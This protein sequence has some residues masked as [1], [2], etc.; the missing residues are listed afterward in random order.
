MRE[1]TFRPSFHFALHAGVGFVLCFLTACST[2]STTPNSLKESAEPQERILGESYDDVWRAVQLAMGNYP[3]KVNNQDAG[4]LETEVIR[5]DS[6]WVSPGQ[7]RPQTGGFRYR[8]I[9]RVIKGRT[10]RNMPA[11]QVTI[12]KMAEL[13]R[14]FFS[15]YERIPS[16][17]LEELALMYRIEREISIEKALRKGL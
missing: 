1:R 9:V 16:D 3:I 10:E 14:D 8:I 5:G 13:Q 17:G 11:A 6:A 4:V 15:A 7:K 12:L 2:P